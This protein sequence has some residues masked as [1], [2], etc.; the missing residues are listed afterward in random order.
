[1]GGQIVDRRALP[2]GYRIEP[3]VSNHDRAA[4]CC[5][6]PEL[7]AYIRQQAG[8]D[9]KRKLAAVFILI[10]D[11]GAVAGFHTLSAHS[12]LAVNLPAEMAKK[13]PRYLIPVTLLGRM[14]VSQ[15]LQ[16]LGLGELLLMDALERA[17]M[18]SRHAASWAV[19]VNTKA[20]AREFYL[21]HGFVPFPDQPG[22]LGLQMKT[23]E[24]MSQA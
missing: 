4:F 17:W 10:A 7:D 18:A 5:G 12:I 24:L 14:A 20:G 15:A 19:V 6:N 16:G 11:S 13:L 1:M 22:R 3:L 2:A 21:K 9:Q 23:I 8:Q